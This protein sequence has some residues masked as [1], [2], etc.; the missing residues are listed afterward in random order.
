MDKI[1]LAMD[2]ATHYHKNQCR[3]GTNIP[4]IIH[5]VSA[6][7]NAWKYG[8]R[9]N[10]ILV[11]VI[12]HD[13]LEDTE[14]TPQKLKAEFGEKVLQIVQDVSEQD[15]DMDWKPR[16]DAYLA[17][18]ANEACDEAVIV[19]TLDKIENLQSIIEDYTYLGDQMFS[20]FSAPKEDQIWFYTTFYE[21]VK[22]KAIFQTEPYGVVL[23][24]LEQVVKRL[25]T[26][27]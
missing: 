16:K 27:A 24:T 15:K 8:V 23:D 25:K 11:S 1:R 22:D 12:L 5:P 21:T 13:T 6:Y 2:T 20:R 9:D 26:I 10:D 14:Y 4:Y 19:S 3:K 17:H 7:A 18:L